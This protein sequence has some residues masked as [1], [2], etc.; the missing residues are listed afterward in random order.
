MRLRESAYSLSDPRLIFGQTA[1][2]TSNRKFQAWKRV[3]ARLLQKPAEN[4]ILCENK[5]SGAHVGPGLVLPSSFLWGADN[6]MS[7]YQNAD[8]FRRSRHL[9]DIQ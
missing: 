8:I 2:E 5:R 3:E 7:I 6:W 4:Q 9:V 1:R